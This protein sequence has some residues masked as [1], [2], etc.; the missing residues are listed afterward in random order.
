MEA[1]TSPIRKNSIM[2]VKSTVGLDHR[3]ALALF[4]KA[5]SVPKIILLAPLDRLFRY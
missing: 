3:E 5:L 1:I 2:G 4:T